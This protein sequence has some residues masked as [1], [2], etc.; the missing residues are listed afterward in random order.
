MFIKSNQRFNYAKNYLVLLCNYLRMKPYTDCGGSRKYRNGQTPLELCQ[1][2]IKVNDWINF[3]LNLKS[4]SNRKFE[5][6]QFIYASFNGITLKLVY[7]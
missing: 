4:K 7:F 6:I 5:K 3:L 2:K 1:A